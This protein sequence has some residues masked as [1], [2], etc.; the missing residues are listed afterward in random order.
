M[1]HTLRS[2]DVQ[3]SFALPCPPWLKVIG[4]ER[5]W[6]FPE[7]TMCRHIHAH[8]HRQSWGLCLGCWVNDEWIHEIKEW[9]DLSLHSHPSNGLPISVA[10][11]SASQLPDGFSSLSIFA[12]ALCFLSQCFYCHSDTFYLYPAF[13]FLVPFLSNLLT[14]LCSY[15]PGLEEIFPESFFSTL[16]FFYY[17]CVSRSWKQYLVFL[18]ALL[19]P[20]T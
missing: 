1:A 11:S 15:T 7:V 19:E 3:V 9:E 18:M 16:N 4:Q 6:V 13:K 10:I 14:S 8:A 5:S 20:A 2:K 17:L 12:L